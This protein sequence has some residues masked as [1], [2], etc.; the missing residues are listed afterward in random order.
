MKSTGAKFFHAF[1][2]SIIVTALWVA[3]IN[4]AQFGYERVFPINPVTIGNAIVFALIYVVVHTV[5]KLQ[6]SF[7]SAFVSAMINELIVLA[8]AIYA[9]TFKGWSL[10]SIFVLL[11][12][13]VMVAGMTHLFA[14]KFRI[15]RRH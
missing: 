9:G 8:I 14:T 7:K 6:P 12:L 4:Y 1:I 11:L 2:G 13:P 10:L 5:G 3:V 15:L